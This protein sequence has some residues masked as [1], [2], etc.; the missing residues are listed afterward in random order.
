MQELETKRRK[1]FLRHFSDEFED[2]YEVNGSD[3]SGFDLNGSYQNDAFRDEGNCCD[4]LEEYEYEDNCGDESDDDIFEEQACNRNEKSDGGFEFNSVNNKIVL[5]P[6][7]LFV[8]MSEFRK[9][10]KVFAIRNGF[11][12]KRLK[13]EKTRITCVCA[14]PNCTWRS[15]QVL[16][17]TE[18][19]SRL[20]PTTQSTHVLE[21]MTIMRQLQI[22]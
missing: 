17:G 21:L 14:T 12:L 19:Y 20:R 7:Q 8:N 2:D 16:I 9:V 13:N 10:L 1:I 3:S 22:G 11:R 4:D 18:G 5:R 15:M 6:G